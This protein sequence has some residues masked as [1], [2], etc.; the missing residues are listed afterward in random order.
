MKLPKKYLIGGTILITVLTAYFIFGPASEKQFYEFE[1]ASNKA[2]Q[3]IFYNVDMR[4]YEKVRS[5]FTKNLKRFEARELINLVKKQ[6]YNQRYKDL[7]K[8]WGL[9]SVKI[10]E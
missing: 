6:K 7:I 10:E 4:K 1:V 9:T 8:K 3:F 5:D 2:K